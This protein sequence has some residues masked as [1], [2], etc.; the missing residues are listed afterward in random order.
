MLGVRRAGVTQAAQKLLEEGIIQ[1]SRG[2]IQILDQ[3]KLEKTS[4]ECFR[5]VKNEHERLLGRKQK[6]CF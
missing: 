3:Q 2:L 1:Y 5:T 6:N 4:C